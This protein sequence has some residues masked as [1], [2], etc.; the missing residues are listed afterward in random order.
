MKQKWMGGALF[1]AGGL[2]LIVA[3]GS[4]VPWTQKLFLGILGAVFVLMAVSIFIKRDPP[5]NQ[6]TPE[7]EAYRREEHVSEENQQIE[8]QPAESKQIE[9]RLEESKQ[10]ENKREA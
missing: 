1:A 8:N 7:R 10:D 4:Q 6:G 2:D 5:A 3:V 9:N